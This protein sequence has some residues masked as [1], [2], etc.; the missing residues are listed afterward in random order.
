MDV[1]EVSGSYEAVKWDLVQ[2]RVYRMDGVCRLGGNGQIMPRMRFEALKAYLDKARRTF[3]ADT[4]RLGWP[5]FLK[6]R[7]FLIGRFLD[8]VVEEPH[9][10]L[11]EERHR[12]IS[13]KARFTVSDCGRAR[14]LLAGEYDFADEE[15]IPSD[16]V[17]FSWLKRGPSKEWEMGPVSDKGMVA[18]SSIVHPSGKMTFTVL[19][20]IELHPDR[21]TLECMSRERLE[22]GKKRLLD[23]LQGT[24]RHR[25]DEFEDIH[26]AME[27]DKGKDGGTKPIIT[28]EARA[29][30]VSMMQKHFSAWPDQELPALGGKTPR[31][32]V[33]TKAGREKVLELIKNLENGEARKKKAGEPFVDLGPLR[34]ELGMEG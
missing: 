27:R 12:I 8:E 15:E 33:A 23:L 22:R 6:E 2:M 21:M 13:A 31:E 9:V 20:T 32:A 26:V 11:T 4:G 14:K 24:V 30:L 1:E 3:E 10:L 34:R 29:M 18:T 16:G 25:V 5:A 7:A 17:S 28:E 19:G